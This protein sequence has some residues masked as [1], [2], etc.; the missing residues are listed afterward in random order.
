MQVLLDVKAALSHVTTTTPS[1]LLR[2]LSTDPLFCNEFNSLLAT[3]NVGVAENSVNGW[4]NTAQDSCQ[5]LL[6]VKLLQE[7]LFRLQKAIESGDIPGAS[8]KDFNSENIVKICDCFL[9]GTSSERIA[10]HLSLY[11]PTI[12][13]FQ[14]QECFYL[15]F[16]S[17][18]K[19]SEYLFKLLSDL[20][21]QLYK[22]EPKLPK[23]TN[24]DTRLPAES[25]K[26][27]RNRF[28]KFSSGYSYLL[29]TLEVNSK[30]RC[31]FAWTD[32]NHSG[33]KALPDDHVFPLQSILLSR[34]QFFKEAE[35]VSTSALRNFTGT[36][37][38]RYGDQK[39][40]RSNFRYGIIFI[41]GT[42]GLD[43]LICDI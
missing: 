9:L 35:S 43:W 22:S 7:Y 26:Q 11:G 19:C 33:F 15:L 27:L 28:S 21:Q 18:L 25:W 42:I 39:E 2:Q 20:H 23:V 6:R 4:S 40:N 32:P 10:E 17:E 34:Q 29:D 1:T 37:R 16:E 13:Q 12:S 31:V 38:I 24:Y 30:A 5:L 3:A 8:M 14:L 41:I 36:T